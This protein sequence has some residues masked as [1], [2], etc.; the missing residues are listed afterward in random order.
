MFCIP[1]F[2]L[3][4]WFLSL[5][6]LAIPS[7]CLK[8]FIYAASSLCSS[9][10]FSTQASLPN[11]KA[12][13]A[14]I[15]WILTFVSLVICFPKFLHITPFIL[16]YVCILSSKSLSQ[17][18]IRYPK[19]LNSDTCLIGLSFMTICC[20]LININVLELKYHIG[21]QLFAGRSRT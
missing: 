20:F 19:Y 4:D 13:F 8:N 9:R 7:K 14:V 16:L 11:F 21:L 2:S 3:T 15:L 12:A 1:S 18:D 5:S 6:N 10:F 17:S